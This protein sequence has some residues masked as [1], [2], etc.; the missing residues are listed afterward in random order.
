M[1]TETPTLPDL[2]CAP[3]HLAAHL[4]PLSYPYIKKV[5]VSKCCPE[6][7][8]LFQAVIE[9]KGGEVMRSSSLQFKLNEICR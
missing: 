6:C 9:S 3:L 5:S 1:E 7:G 8:D 4:C 2:T